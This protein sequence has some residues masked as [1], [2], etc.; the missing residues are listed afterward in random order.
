MSRY[1][2]S[3]ESIHMGSTSLILL[4]DDEV[5][6]TEEAMASSSMTAEVAMVLGVNPPRSLQAIL[7]TSGRHVS[8]ITALLTRGRLYCKVRAVVY[9]L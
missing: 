2:E 1:S 5:F 6:G 8:I 7:T 9:T 3:E 4:F